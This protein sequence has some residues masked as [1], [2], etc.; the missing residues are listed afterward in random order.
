MQ[1]S[2]TYFSVDCSSKTRRR[3][4]LPEAEPLVPSSLVLLVVGAVADICKRF[5]EVDTGWLWNKYSAV[6][7]RIASLSSSSRDSV[8]PPIYWCGLIRLYILRWPFGMDSHRIARWIAESPSDWRNQTSGTESAF[9]R[10][11]GNHVSDQSGWRSSGNW[12]PTAKRS[13]S[14]SFRLPTFWLGTLCVGRDSLFAI[15][16][17]LGQTIQITNNANN[18]NSNKK[19]HFFLVSSQSHSTAKW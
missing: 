5:A 3:C 10:S 14:T 17:A 16:L 18:S 15:I 19:M 2:I 7:E 11:D 12:R 1:F 4:N 13:Q 6:A 9:L 8:R